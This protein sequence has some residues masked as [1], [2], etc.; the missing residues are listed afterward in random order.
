MYNVNIRDGDVTRI[1]QSVGSKLKK[2]LNIFLLNL[3]NILFIIFMVEFQLEN[4]VYILS[5][6]FSKLCHRFERTKCESTSVREGRD[7]EKTT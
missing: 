7:G 6:S 1:H 2:Y 3:I 4:K 5:P